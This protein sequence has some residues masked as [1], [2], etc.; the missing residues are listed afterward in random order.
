MR[1]LPWERPSRIKE[2]RE[3]IWSYV[4]PSSR[5]EGP[6][7]VV[8]D[9]MLGWPDGDVTELAALQFLLSAEVGDFVHQLPELARR[10]STTSVH[11]EERGTE[12]IRGAINWG[13]TMSARLASGAPRLHVTTPVERAYQTPE[14]ELLVHVLDAI[15]RLGTATGWA[16]PNLRSEPATT[17]RAHLTEAK[18][19]Q[20]TSMLTPIRRVTPTPRSLARI[21]SGRS[22]VRYQGVLAAYSRL[23]ALVER[24]DREAIR[25]AIE[26]VGLV[27]SKEHILFELLP[28]F[29]TIA[30]LENHAWQLRPLRLFAG[31]VETQGL[32]SD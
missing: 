14:N 3:Q 2:I 10:L 30:S 26:D 28:L 31:A 19:W 20:S 8:A 15:V 5:R 27:A 4:S 25:S 6:G 13:E 22:H 18:R 1:P 32:G 11:D 29:R 7:L 21:G 24:L 16:R 23:D 9:A 12:R 17:T